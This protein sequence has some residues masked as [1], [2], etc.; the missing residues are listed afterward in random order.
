M[1][2]KKFILFLIVWQSLIT[3]TK[4]DESSSKSLIPSDLLDSKETFQANVDTILLIFNS[5]YTNL[6]NQTNSLKEKRKKVLS[7]I[8]KLEDDIDISMIEMKKSIHRIVE[9]FSVPIARDQND[10]ICSK[11]NGFYVML[12]FYTTVYEYSFEKV[13]IFLDLERE[14]QANIS[15][16]NENTIRGISDELNSLSCAYEEFYND[17]LATN[18]LLK[19]ILF[20]F[21]EYFPLDGCL[22]ELSCGKF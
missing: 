9:F 19:K 3:I 21:I 18:D 22:K 4:G 10:T 1:K 16:R 2:R 12:D 20:K 8:E 6:A 5:K 7:K 11:F 15:S 17:V 13:K 14:F